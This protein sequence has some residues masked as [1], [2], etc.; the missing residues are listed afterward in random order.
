[1]ITYWAS[2][3]FQALCWA[4]SH[5]VFFN[6]SR[7]SPHLI[8]EET[9]SSNLALKGGFFDS[10]FSSPQGLIQCVVPC[11]DSVYLMTE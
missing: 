4:L 6:W 3:V 7:I 1:M 8:D 2:V 10:F 11:E 5:T 9:E